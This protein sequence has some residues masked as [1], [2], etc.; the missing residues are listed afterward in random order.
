MEREKESVCFVSWV[1]AIPLLFPALSPV[2]WKY[3]LTQESSTPRRLLYK[4][5]LTH[6]P[7]TEMPVKK[8]IRKKERKYLHTK[9]HFTL[10]Q[11][12]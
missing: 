9:I 4:H 7:R 10:F 12:F 3:I 2:D 11:T 1:T 6:K 5:S 8:R